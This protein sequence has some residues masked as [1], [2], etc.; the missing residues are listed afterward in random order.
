MPFDDVYLVSDKLAT[1]PDEQLTLLEGRL[2]VPLP[3]GYRDF[4]RTLGI[5]TYCD[6]IRVYE[7]ERIWRGYRDARKIWSEHFFWDAGRDV[8]TKEQVLSSFLF[9]DSIDSDQL[10]LCPGIT[11]RLFVLPRHD[12]T[13]YRAPCG[14]TEP[15][16]WRSRAGLV[17]EPPPFKVF[18][19]WRDR[20]YVELFTAT[21]TLEMREVAYRV[22][23]RWRNA[24]AREVEEDD[25]VLIFIK[26]IGG[27]AQVV[28][29]SD[30]R[31]RI[32]VDYDTDSVGEVAALAASLKELGFYETGRS[33]RKK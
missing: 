4:M 7:P 15:C 16:E 12:S 28:Q 18:E 3:Y 21:R 17:N 22:L 20:A 27:R 32:R 24:L 10:I 14:F 31:I 8:L 25:M 26:E 6:F 29:V 30:G 2:G 9:A 13:I 1:I 5:G 33:Q 23:S 11:D 19:P